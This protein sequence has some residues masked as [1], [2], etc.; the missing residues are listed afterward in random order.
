[1]NELCR[2]PHGAVGLLSLAFL[3][4][5]CTVPS[6]VR[7]L[8]IHSILLLPLLPLP[9]AS[10]STDVNTRLSPLLFQC[11]YFRIFRLFTSRKSPCSSLT[12]T[13]SLTH[14]FVLLSVQLTLS[15]LLHNHI[16]NAWIIFS[17]C[18]LSV[19]VSHA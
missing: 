3:C 14:S 16:S 6:E 2:S 10:P 4:A 17:S 9:S 8:E 13:L 18:F 19:Q 12:P 11:L 5:S 7:I 15:T 1:M